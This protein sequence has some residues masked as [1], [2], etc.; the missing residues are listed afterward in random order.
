MYLCIDVG[1]TKTLV[2]LFTTHGRLTKHIRFATPKK[3]DEFFAVLSQQVNAHFDLKKCTRLAIAVPGP[4][5]NGQPLFFGN[6]PWH[7]ADFKARLTIMFRLPTTVFNDAFASAYAETRRRPFGTSVYITLSTG[8]GTGVI[9]DGK[10]NPKYVNF[11]PGHI[12]FD[13][14][15]E[16]LEWED[17]AAASAVSKAYGSKVTEITGDKA[18]ADI[19]HRISTGLLLV[20]KE[21]EPNR[22][23]FGGPLGLMLPRYH[24][25]L[26]A[27]LRAGLPKDVRLPHLAK[28]HYKTESVLYGCYHLIRK[29]R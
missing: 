6:L 20:I 1:G 17:I 9:T 26:A 4:V 13:W 2:G 16:L 27:R 7:P 11:E 25:H 5:R 14:Q 24:R 12:K 22:V 29:N 23:I 15:G 8:I 28:P 21:V 3:E 18:W 19:A 10:A